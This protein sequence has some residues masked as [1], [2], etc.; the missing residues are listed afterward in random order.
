MLEILDK[1]TEYLI[2]YRLPLREWADFTVMFLRS[3]Y[4][5]FFRS[6]SGVVEGAVNYFEAYLSVIPITL[7]ILIMVLIAWKLAGRGVAIFTLIGLLLIV[8][9]NIWDD[10]IL[11]WPLCVDLYCYYRYSHN[12][13]RVMNLRE[14]YTSYP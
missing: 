9:M 6:I 12:S 1:W 2:M 11:L 3:N 5:D 4:R 7:F 10:T 8:S 14:H 13:L